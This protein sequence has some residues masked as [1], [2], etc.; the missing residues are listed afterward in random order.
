[1]KSNQ[2]VVTGRS[3][4]QISQRETTNPSGFESPGGGI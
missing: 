3:L 4:V 1:M 2:L